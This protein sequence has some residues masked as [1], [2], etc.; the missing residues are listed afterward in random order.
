MPLDLLENRLAQALAL[1]SKWAT[2]SFICVYYSFLDS[3]TKAILLVYTYDFI[4]RS[5]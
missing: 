1:R 4:L 5:W 2:G 3:G